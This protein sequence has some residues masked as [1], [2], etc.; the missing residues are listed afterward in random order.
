MSYSDSF[1]D[2]NRKN[3]TQRVCSICQEKSAHIRGD[4]DRRTCSYVYFDQNGRKWSGRRC[5]N[6]VSAQRMGRREMKH[7]KRL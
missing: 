1:N 5:P 6:C 7:E 4:F 2:F 3:D